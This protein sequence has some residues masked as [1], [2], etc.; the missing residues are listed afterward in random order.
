MID[1][2]IRHAA[3]EAAARILTLRGSLDLEYKLEQI[4]NYE[5]KMSEPDFWDDNERAQK[6]IAESNALKSVVDQYEKLAQQQ[7]DLAAMIELVEEENDES[8]EAEIREAA[9]E[10][11]A[12]LK[13][14]ELQLMLNGPYDKNNAILELHPGAGGTESQDWAEMLLR[15][16]R[17]WAE[18]HEYKVEVL[19]YLP[20][21]EAGVKSVTLL[22][23]GHNAY[24]YLKAEKGVHR[25]VRISPFDASGRRHTSFVSC[26]VMPEIDDDNSEIEVRPEDLRIDTYRSSGAGGQHVNKT[27]S[28]VRIT[29]IPTGIVTA[30]QTERSQIQNRE[31]AM[32]M[33][34]SKLLERRLE[35]QQ[36]EIAEI[37]GEQL[38]IG[39]GSQIRSYVFHPYSMVK[40]HRTNVETGNV[41]AVMD[42]ELDPFIDAY[43]RKEI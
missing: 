26:D 17:R 6:L 43:L 28:A 40:D 7:E 12:G 24:G 15:M 25:L 29:H 35:E 33:L 39:W 37:K 9:D 18:Q 14:F 41:Q 36:K 11:M 38:E 19:D 23:R 32:R 1:A 3:K 31:R 4:E 16:Y 10:L 34:K 2:E 30:C 22:I 27:E 8:L 21:D 5:V 42:G 20:G 13:A